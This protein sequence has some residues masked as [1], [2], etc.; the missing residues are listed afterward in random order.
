MQEHVFTLPTFFKYEIG[1]LHYYFKHIVITTSSHKPVNISLTIPGIGVEINKTITKDSSL[2]DI[3]LSRTN[4][5]GRDIRTL[6][7][8][9]KQNTTIIVRSSDLM[10]VHVI[11]NGYGGGDG[12]VVIPT[13]QLETMHYVASYQPSSGYYPAFVCI[14]ALYTNTSVY[15]HT[16]RKRMRVTLLQYES[17]ALTVARMKIYAGVLCKVTTPLS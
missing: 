5:D 8:V 14:T 7:G 4:P 10:S 2:C 11:S 3:D 9:G 17:Y 1:K 12:F 16:K 13:N 15:I 6:F